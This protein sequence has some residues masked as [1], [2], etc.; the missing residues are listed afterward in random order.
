MSKTVLPLEIEYSNFNDNSSL[1]KETVI[2]AEKISSSIKEKQSYYKIFDID[3][4]KEQAKLCI[5]YA[6]EINNNYTDLIVIAMGGA[7]LNPATVIELSN[8]HDSAT[9]IHFLYS[10]DPLVLQ[11]LFSKL[12]LKNCAIL[13]VSNSGETLETIALVGAMIAEFEKAGIIDLGKRFYFIT[14]P[15]E[16]KL[17]KIA[18]KINATI[19]PHTEKISGRYSGL[20]NVTSFAAQVVGID[21]DQYL[22]GANLVIN[23]FLEQKE[24]SQSAI[25]AANIFNAAKPMMINIGYLQQFD[26]YLEWYSQIISESLGK[27]GQGITPVRGLGPNDQHSM[28]Q[29]YLDGPKDKLYSLFYIKESS[30]DLPDYNTCSLEELDY[31]SNKSLTDIHSANFEATKQALINRDLPVR[32][33]V[34]KDLS[35]STIGG[36]VA[37]SMLEV[38][39]LGHIMQINPFN[40]PG[41]ELIKTKSRQIVQGK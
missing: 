7:M 6:K 5:P 4:A 40:Q 38:I 10:T 3:Y 27:D 13:A 32:S 34:I 41:V 11:N 29:L 15:L 31:I 9:K 1:Q 18:Q 19:L 26:S 23:D 12:R 36:L 20:T 22:S 16:G 8:K 39:I 30:Q 17:Y 33:I 35:S 2:A 37:Y 14:N 21:M 24:N 28:L 25:S